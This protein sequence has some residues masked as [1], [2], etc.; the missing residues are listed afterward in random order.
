P[1]VWVG[2]R[3]QVNADGTVKAAGPATHS[4]TRD[5]TWGFGSRKTSDFS[6][7]A[8]Q[9]FE[10][11]YYGAPYMQNISAWPHTG[12]ENVKLF[13]EFG[14]LLRNAFGFARN[15]GVKTC[16]GTEA[17]LSVPQSVWEK[18]YLEGKDPDTEAETKQAVYE[19]VFT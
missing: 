8:A 3:D 17:P 14:G 2:T 7:G 1:M 13:N 19:G 9:L 6:F 12:Q 5:E 10:A 18:L 4:Y 15:L 16:L 11:D